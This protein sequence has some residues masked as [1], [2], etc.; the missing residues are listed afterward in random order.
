MNRCIMVNIRFCWCFSS[1][2]SGSF[3][4]DGVFFFVFFFTDPVNQVGINQRRGRQ[5][6]QYVDKST[7]QHSWET[8]K[9]LS[10][11]NGNR[12]T[13]TSAVAFMIVLLSLRVQFHW[14]QNIQVRS[15]K[16]KSIGNGRRSNKLRESG[17]N[18][19]DESPS[20]PQSA[21]MSKHRILKLLEII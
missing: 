7:M 16:G 1:C 17:H 6:C 5:Y 3:V 15:L 21:G 19:K 2:T 13:I 11:K 12:P 8:C 9:A 14:I 20:S 10:Q 4:K 18:E